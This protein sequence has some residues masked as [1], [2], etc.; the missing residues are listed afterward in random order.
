MSLVIT[1]IGIFWYYKKFK[2]LNELDD[3]G[4]IAIQHLEA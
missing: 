2:L 3:R 4:L 1:R